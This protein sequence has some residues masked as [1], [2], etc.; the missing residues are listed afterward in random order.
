[1]YHCHHRLQPMKD[2]GFSLNTPQSATRSTPA[3]LSSSSILPNHLLLLLSGLTWNIRSYVFLC[4][5]LAYFILAI[6]ISINIPCSLASCDSSLFL[7][8][9]RFNNIVSNTILK[10]DKETKPKFY[11]HLFRTDQKLLTKS[12]FIILDNTGSCNISDK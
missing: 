4:G 5:G 6:L 3:L 10:V 12:I 7:L 9:L 8:I 2:P 11:C 1:M